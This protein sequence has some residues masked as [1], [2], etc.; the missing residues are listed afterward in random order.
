MRKKK[1]L[2]GSEMMR[3]LERMVFLQIIDGKWK[4]HLYSMDKCAKALV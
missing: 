1:K 2:A 4:D 3:Y